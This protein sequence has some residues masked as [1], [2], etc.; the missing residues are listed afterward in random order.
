M[1]R[2]PAVFALVSDGVQK[3]LVAEGAE[4]DLVELPLH[5][6]VPVHLVYLILALT[7]GTLT[8]ETARSVERPLA[9]VLLD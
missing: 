7:D 4:N 1:A 9:N 2:V 6:L 8:A 5:E 3:E